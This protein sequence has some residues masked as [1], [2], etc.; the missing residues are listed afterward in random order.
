MFRE[1]S[2]PRRID[3]LLP[4]GATALAAVFGFLCVT[5]VDD[6][7]G[8]LLLLFGV[9]P[10][11]LVAFFILARAGRNWV[12]FEIALLIIVASAGIWLVATN[13][14]ETR[15]IVRWAIYAS[16]YKE[17]AITAPNVSGDYLKHTEWDG[18]GFPGAGNTVEYLVFDPGNS[19]AASANMTHVGKVD[20]IPCPIAQTTFVENQW[21]VVLF[22][23]GTDWGYC[24]A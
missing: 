23:T 21:Y 6:D 10:C 11:L 18:W 7:S 9:A 14:H 24:S 16:A 2:L 20:G 3:W 8:I 12:R 22:Y 5:V 1:M 4:L 13:F 17:R 19:L 15:R